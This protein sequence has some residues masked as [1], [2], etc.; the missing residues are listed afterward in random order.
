MSNVFQHSCFISYRNGS[1]NDL[2][3]TFATQIHE[4]LHSELESQLDEMTV[5]L[6]REV[7]E[8]GQVL[9]IKVGGALCRSIC[10]VIIFTRNY[11]SEKKLFCAA[12]LYAMLQ[13][14]ESRFEKIKQDNFENGLIITIALRNSD[15]IPD[16]LRERL[17]YDFSKYTLSEAPIKANP[18]Y[19]SQ[20]Q[21]IANYIAE[22]YDE[23]K[24]N[25]AELCE[26]CKDFTLPDIFS[27]LGKSLM[28]DFVNK[29]R[30]NYDSK[31]QS[32]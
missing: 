12:E 10:M 1:R 16:I 8:G 23:M 2:L 5:F 4:A 17:F 26:P 32:S 14:E 21:K 13:C 27:K 30:K 11:L 3:D 29:H 28:A 15:K 19:N 20:I 24:K 31:L 9:H 6:D 18:N 22:R 7:L 25:E